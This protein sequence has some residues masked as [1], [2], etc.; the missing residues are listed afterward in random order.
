[1]NL[2]NT[3]ATASKTE[4]R[5]DRALRAGSNPVSWIV[6]ETLTDG[7]VTFSV[8]MDGI[9]GERV[10]I[11]AASQQFAEQINEAINAGGCWVQVQP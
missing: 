4:T 8:V 3:M 2:E 5:E 11:A 1:M 10:V 7:S 6:P 9:D